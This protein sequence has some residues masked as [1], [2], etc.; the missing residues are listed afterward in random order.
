MTESRE[1]ADKIAEFV[2]DLM[3]PF[4]DAVAE[5]QKSQEIAKAAMEVLRTGKPVVIHGLRIAKAPVTG[6]YKKP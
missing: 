3:K 2:K 5:Y 4:N 1:Q 6:K